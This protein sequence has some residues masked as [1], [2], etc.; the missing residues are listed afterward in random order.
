MKRGAKFVVSMDD[1][2]GNS[3]RCS[4]SYKGMIDDV[5]V[6]D[7]ILIDDGLVGIKLKKLRVMT[8]IQ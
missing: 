4:V 6:G 5:K 8:Y 2:I 3:Q 7:T 1:C